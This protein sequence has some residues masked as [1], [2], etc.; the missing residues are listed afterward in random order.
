M[1]TN[2]NSNTDLSTSLRGTRSE[3]SRT[4]SASQPEAQPADVQKTETSAVNLSDTA[5]ELQKIT[6]SEEAPIRQD[7]VDALKAALARGESVIDSD[8]VARNMLDLEW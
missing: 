5:R 6:Q 2:I 4:R 1:V 3:S 8:A 7:K